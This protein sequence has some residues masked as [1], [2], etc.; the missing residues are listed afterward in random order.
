MF[1][2]D[3]W[4]ICWCWADQ[5][6]VR[7]IW[8]LMETSP[9]TTC[10]IIFTLISILQWHPGVTL[11]SNSKLIFFF[12]VARIPIIVMLGYSFVWPRE[13]LH[14]NQSDFYAT[15]WH[16]GP[17][18]EPIMFWRRSDSRGGAWRIYCIC[19]YSIWAWWKSA[20]N[21]AMHLKIQYMTVKFNSGQT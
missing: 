6:V 1:L 9:G 17:K 19:R 3:L 15:W 14:K 10:I 16:G 20:V 8:S 13:E 12:V 7:L 5:K 21:N 18:D 4:V 11:S 2:C